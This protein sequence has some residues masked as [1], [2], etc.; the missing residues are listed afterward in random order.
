MVRMDPRVRVP[1]AVLARKFA[2]ERQ[3]AE[4]L[5]WQSG[6]L[7]AARTGR[8]SAEPDSTE[9]ALVRLGRD[10]NAIYRVVYEVDAAPTAEAERQYRRL[11]R[12][13]ADIRTRVR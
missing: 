7:A 10:L 9:A 13:M 1:E 12:D 5:T 4:W 8:G 11:E 6:V 2:I 3:V